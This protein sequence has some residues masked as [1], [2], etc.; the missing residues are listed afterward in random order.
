[1][2]VLQRQIERNV[3]IYVIHEVII[4]ILDENVNLFPIS[5]RRLMFMSVQNQL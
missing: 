5:V 1:M 3:R 4:I 2:Q